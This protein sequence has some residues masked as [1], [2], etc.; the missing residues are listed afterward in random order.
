MDIGCGNGSFLAFMRE[1]GWDVMGIEPDEHAARIA[2]QQFK[3]PVRIGTCEKM[4]FPK[5]SFDA[6][7]MSNVIEH[8]HDPLL[9][10]RHCFE[11]LKPGGKLAIVTANVNS[12]AHRLFKKNWSY[13]H[14]PYHLTLFSPRALRYV[15][16][17]AGFRTLYLGTSALSAAQIYRDSLTFRYGRKA[18][19]VKLRDL[20]F[21]VIEY[22][23]NLI[24]CEMGENIG[25]LAIKEDV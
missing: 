23:V 3:V 2:Q 20:S 19:P 12:L 11:V 10:I 7:T 21:M 6:I 18:M 15:V 14:P 8:L 25:L 22:L 1:L 4:D 5:S 17:T 13:L 24:Q 16:E 9:G